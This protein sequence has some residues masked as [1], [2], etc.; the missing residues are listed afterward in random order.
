MSGNRHRIAWWTL[1]SLFVIGL[2]VPSVVQPTFD[3]SSSIFIAFVAYGCVG[4]V[5]ALRRPANPIGWVFLGIGA[6]AGLT[7]AALSSVD[8]ARAQGEPIALWGLL[9]AWFLSWLWFPL[10]FLC[11]TFTVL[12]YP[13][14]LPSSRWQP[15]QRIAIVSVVVMTTLAA[16]SPTVS[17]DVDG[18]GPFVDNPLSPAFMAQLKPIGVPIF[19]IAA[20]AAVGCGFAAVASVVV[21]ARRAT[22]VE[23]QQLH[24]FAFAV[25]LA[26]PAFM[27]SS[28]DTFV[29]QLP[30]SIGLAFVPISCGIAI[31]RYH[32]YDIDQIISRTTSYALVTALLLLVYVGVVAAAGW[33]LPVSDSLAVAAATLTAAALIRPVLSRVQAV[34]DRRFNRSRYDAELVVQEFGSRLRDEVDPDE[35]S[36]DLVSVLE[37]TL[38]PDGATVWVREL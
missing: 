7:Q 22:G 25:V 33:L 8:L 36:A 5:V 17:L 18:K 32:L 21:R 12:N 29:G 26:I 13:E 9:G 4:S 2:T 27:A 3:G 24:W 20:L 37:R 6:L 14:G 16:L 28:S 35:V 31:L 34:V 11:T 1:T 38:Q 30:F 10:I 19:A 15:V 23:R